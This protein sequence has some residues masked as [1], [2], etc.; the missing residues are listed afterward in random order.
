MTHLEDDENASCSVA[1]MTDSDV[2]VSGV[3]DA[4]L[5]KVSRPGVDSKYY[6]SGCCG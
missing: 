6:T 2:G 5:S 3:H 1:T 4:T